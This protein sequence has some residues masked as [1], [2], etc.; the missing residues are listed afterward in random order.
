MHFIEGVALVL[1]NTVCISKGNFQRA[2]TVVKSRLQLFIL[3]NYITGMILVTQ[4]II[5][6]FDR[7]VKIENQCWIP[8]GAV[9][10]RKIFLFIYLMEPPTPKEQKRGVRFIELAG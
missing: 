9:G 3:I 10:P 8:I 7:K 6:Y 2:I 1:S 4:A 5:L